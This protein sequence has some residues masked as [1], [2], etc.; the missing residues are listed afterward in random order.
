MYLLRRLGLVGLPLF[1]CFLFICPAHV[2]AEPVVAADAAILIESTTG[3]VIWEKNADAAYQPASM[4][5]MMTCLLALHSLKVHELV[6]ISAAAAATESSPLGLRAGEQLEADELIHGMMMISD[7]GAAVALAEKIGG[8]VPAFVD[9]MNAEAAALGM[10]GTHFHNP[11]GLTDPLHYS[12]ARDMATLT[13]HAMRERN[14][15]NIVGQPQML[16][17]WSRP[18]VKFQLFQNTNE[19]LKTYQGATGVKTGWTQAAGG[20]LAASARREGLELIA[21]VM[22]APTE[23]Q[24]FR[25]AQAM[26]D[27]GFQHVRMVRGYAQANLT[28]QC[29]V[30]GASQAST[31][32]RA[33]AD[34]NYPLIDEEDASRYAISYD[35]PR[36]LTGPI[37]DGQVVGQLVV[38]Y[39]GE[40]V[41]SIDMQADGV[42]PGFSL[43]GWLVGVFAPVL[44]L[45]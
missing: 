21:I 37:K 43:G 6:P 30:S 33:A 9:K 29:W 38:R 23:A 19:L 42:A 8:S 12:T 15:R 2:G 1:L 27:Y 40:P 24:R 34:V 18:Q 28:Q 39:D 36:V 35:L 31:T 45:V 4:T 44:A 14:F 16:I 22:H 32:V 41:G 10:T 7:N 26:L 13:R 5:K 17:K 25:D 20:C 3:R 11:N